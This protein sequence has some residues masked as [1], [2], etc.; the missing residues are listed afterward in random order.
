MADDSGSDRTGDANTSYLL[1]RKA[2]RRAA[3]P[4]TGSSPLALEAT[5]ASIS[6]EV[7]TEAVQRRYRDAKA[8]TAPSPTGA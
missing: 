5:L 7:T 2:I 1:H 8:S 6:A 3:F 4:T